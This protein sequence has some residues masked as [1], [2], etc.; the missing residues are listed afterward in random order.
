[1]ELHRYLIDTSEPFRGVTTS[2]T[3]LDTNKVERVA[4]SGFLYAKD[5]V[6]M[7]LEEYLELRK[8]K[9][10]LVLTWEEFEPMLMEFNNSLKTK[11]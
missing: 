11:P 10:F 2:A 7:T 8:D 6:D 5:K 3:Y 9:P 1:M 4:Y